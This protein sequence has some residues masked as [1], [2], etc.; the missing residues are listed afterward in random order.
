MSKH[1]NFTAIHWGRATIKE[2]PVIIDST[3][4]N[5]GESL[6]MKAFRSMVTQPLL[7]DPPK[8]DIPKLLIFNDNE[9]NT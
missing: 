9:Q 5:F 8:Q 2:K 3:I 1:N 4:T 6:T 7:I